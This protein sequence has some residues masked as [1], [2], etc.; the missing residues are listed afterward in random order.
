MTLESYQIL[1]FSF[2]KLIN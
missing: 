1:H 2:E